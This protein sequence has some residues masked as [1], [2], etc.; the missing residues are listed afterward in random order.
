MTL[1]EVEFQRRVVL[2]VEHHEAHG[3][4]ADLVH[5]LAQRDEIA[6]RFDIFTGSP[7]ASA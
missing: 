1:G 3:V 7:R 6:R 5:H 4:D 2:A